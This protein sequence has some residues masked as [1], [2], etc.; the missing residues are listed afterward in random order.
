M[1]TLDVIL[2]GNNYRIRNEVA[3]AFNTVVHEGVGLINEWWTNG[4]ANDDNDDVMDL[5]LAGSPIREYYTQPPGMALKVSVM[6][7]HPLLPGVR[8]GYCCFP[9][10]SGPIYRV[11]ED[12]KMI[13]A[14][15]PILQPEEHHVPGLGPVD[16]GLHRRPPG[17]WPSGGGYTLRHAH[18]IKAL[19]LKADYFFNLVAW[20]AEPRRLQEN[21]LII[22]PTG[23][24]MG[25]T[26]FG[27]ETMRPG[28]LKNA[29]SC[30]FRP[31]ACHAEKTRGLPLPFLQRGR[32]QGES[33]VI[34]GAEK[35]FDVNVRL[36]S[37][38]EIDEVFGHG[39][40][41]TT[42]SAHPWR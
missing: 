1:R 21:H 29:R 23:G 9:W 32:P 8:K 22:N 13:M 20:L 2:L 16:A 27:I 10:G 39:Q 14:K 25:K 38:L 17:P 7:E 40:Q 31:G 41:R 36:C 6:E 42:G 35:E 15:E 33:P 12:A 18:F 24:A 19:G 37:V 26:T 11:R 34:H 30:R 3:A 5:M 4:L 28:T